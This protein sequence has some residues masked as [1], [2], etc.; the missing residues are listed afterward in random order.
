MFH[1]AERKARKA[2]D[3]SE[4]RTSV[5]AATSSKVHAMPNYLDVSSDNA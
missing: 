1:E 5:H 4:A 2:K 3:K